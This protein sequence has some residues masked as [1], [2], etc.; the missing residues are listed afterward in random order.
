ML[1]INWYE[2]KLKDICHHLKK[3]ENKMKE[4]K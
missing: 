1:R 4:K 3:W 2:L